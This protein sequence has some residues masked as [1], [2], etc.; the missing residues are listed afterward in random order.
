MTIEEYE[1]LKIGN[2]V[3]RPICNKFGCWE[4]ETVTVISKDAF[5]ING[6]NLNKW[7]ATYH[8]ALR[9]MEELIT[10]D[11]YSVSREIGDL[12]H[13]RDLVLKQRSEVRSELENA[14]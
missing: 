4:V 13:W 8:T 9:R 14:T 6:S 3:Y 12:R 5:L 2:I 7:Y 11:I 10:N 1:N